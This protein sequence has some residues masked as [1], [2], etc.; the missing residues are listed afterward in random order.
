MVVFRQIRFIWKKLVVFGQIGCIR[1]RWLYSG[2]VVV[3]GQIDCIR[4]SGCIWKNWLYW[5]KLVETGQNGCIWEKMLYAG[6]VVVFGQK[7]LS[8]EKVDVFWQSGCI[9]ESGCNRV[10]W[11]YLGKDGCIWT[12]VYVFR[13]IRCIWAKLVEFRQ[14]CVILAK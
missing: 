13:Q 8:K 3:F 11:L 1:A 10:N 4:E 9:R 2:K 6:K 7:L 14:K 5:G 12:K